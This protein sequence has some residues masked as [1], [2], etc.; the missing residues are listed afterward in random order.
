[1]KDIAIFGAGGLAKE[2]ASLIE[3]V[4]N[5][6]NNCWNFIGFLMITGSYGGVMCLTTA[7]C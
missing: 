3:R 6:D 5:T 2:I 1:M 4:N 7:K